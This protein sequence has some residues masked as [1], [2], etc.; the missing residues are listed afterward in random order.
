MRICQSAVAILLPK[1][2]PTAEGR[3]KE[4][5]LCSVNTVDHLVRAHRSPSRVRCRL[6]P[7][8]RR[9]SNSDGLPLRIARGRRFFTPTLFH[10]S[11]HEENVTQPNGA[12]RMSTTIGLEPP[13]PTAIK[14][15]AEKLE[16]L[17]FTFCKAATICAIAG[18]YA[19]PVAALAA[20]GLY[21]AA[22]LKGK[23]DSRCVLHW[24]LLIAGFWV[25]VAGAW[26]AGN[27]M[28]WNFLTWWR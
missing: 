17:A 15:P 6:R 25:F 14:S 7:G 22:F 21:V 13:N 4:E 10:G 12:N 1:L 20:A 26:L 23:R 3:E 24:P 18:R 9:T 27:L 5:K 19:L 8:I 28:S 16:S 2:W 11:Q